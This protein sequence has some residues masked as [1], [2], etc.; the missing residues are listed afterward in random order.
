MKI[1]LQLGVNRNRLGVH[2]RNDPAFLQQLIDTH[3]IL[4]VVDVPL[5]CEIT[6]VANVHYLLHD[7]FPRHRIG[8]Q[9]GMEKQS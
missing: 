1:V 8:K 3:Q 5:L 7:L 4:I 9:T 6:A 2:L